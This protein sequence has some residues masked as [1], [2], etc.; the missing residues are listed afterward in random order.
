VRGDN[1]VRG[2]DAGI[3]E[4]PRAIA[5]RRIRSFELCAHLP[6][7]DLSRGP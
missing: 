1:S 6:A 2:G 7:F 5:R 3:D 4:E